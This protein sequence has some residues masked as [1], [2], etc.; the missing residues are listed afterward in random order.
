MIIRFN[1]PQTADDVRRILFHALSECLREIACV[2]DCGEDGIQ[3][4]WS[5]AGDEVDD[6]RVIFVTQEE[7]YR[8]R[9]SPHAGPAISDN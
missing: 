1:D 2:D 6:G 8:R 7:F 3:I 9:Q 5:D 4:Q